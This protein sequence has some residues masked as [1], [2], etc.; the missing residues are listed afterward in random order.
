M[1]AWGCH[2]SR[3]DIYCDIMFRLNNATWFARNPTK[4]PFRF[5][6][7]N[8]HSYLSIW[9]HEV[10]V[11]TWGNIS[12]SYLWSVLQSLWNLNIT[13]HIAV[14]CTFVPR[15]VRCHLHASQ[16]VHQAGSFVWFLLLGQVTKSVFTL[17]LAPVLNLPFTHWNTSME[18]GTVRVNSMSPARART[19]T[20]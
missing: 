7:E 16:V 19:R 18:R 3:T 9:F 4:C 14:S 2:M 15:V 11:T 17:R 12:C 6:L 5:L 13:D 10:S 20:A 8:W 1:G